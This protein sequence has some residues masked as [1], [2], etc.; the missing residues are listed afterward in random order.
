MAR[1][2]VVLHSP[3]F[4]NRKQSKTFATRPEARAYGRKIARDY[5]ITANAAIFSTD[6]PQSLEWLF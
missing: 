5:G 2:G 1:F 4:G 6:N 3:E